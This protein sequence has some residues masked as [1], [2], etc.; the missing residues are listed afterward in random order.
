MW[1]QYPN[2]FYRIDDDTD[3]SVVLRTYPPLSR[4]P[5]LLEPAEV[6]RGMLSKLGRRCRLA[7]SA[8]E[9]NL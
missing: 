1:W 9:S 3:T 4:S 5:L 2:H 7:P 8:S 6:T